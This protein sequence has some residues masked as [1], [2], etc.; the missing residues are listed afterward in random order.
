M[1]R[2][3]RE[4]EAVSETIEFEWDEN[5]RR[6]NVIKHAIDFDDAKEVFSTPWP[7]HP[8]RHALLM[9]VDI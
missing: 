2:H 6:G 4:N 3:N 7:I 9:S 8:C 1:C 5:K